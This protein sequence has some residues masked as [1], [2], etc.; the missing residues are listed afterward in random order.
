MK[1]VTVMKWF[2]RAPRFCKSFGIF[3]A[4]YFIF[5]DTPLYLNKLA[6]HIWADK[7]EWY[8]TMQYKIQMLSFKLL[9]T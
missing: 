8:Q 2:F 4:C 9:H 6:L 3:R 7:L 1:L 5:P